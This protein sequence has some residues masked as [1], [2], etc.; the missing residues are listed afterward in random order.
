M[1]SMMFLL[2]QGN[3]LTGYPATPGITLNFDPGAQSI[4]ITTRVTL[5]GHD[6]SRYRII[7]PRF[8]QRG[9]LNGIVQAEN[10]WKP[11]NELQTTLIYGNIEGLE[12]NGL[13]GNVSSNNFSLVIDTAIKKLS[14]SSF[15]D[16]FSEVN[17][18]VAASSLE[19]VKIEKEFGSADAV[20]SIIDQLVQN[21]K[22]GGR[23]LLLAKTWPVQV[24][25]KTRELE[26]QKNWRILSMETWVNLSV[27]NTYGNASYTLYFTETDDYYL[28]DQYVIGGDSIGD[29]IQYSLFSGY[30]RLYRG[31]PAKIYKLHLSNITR[32]NYAVLPN[33]T[34][35]SMTV[36]HVAHQGVTK[37]IGLDGKYPILKKLV[38]GTLGTTNDTSYIDIGSSDGTT[39]EII[40]PSCIKFVSILEVHGYKLVIED[41]ENLTTCIFAGATG[42][43]INAGSNALDIVIRDSPTM[44]GVFDMSQVDG[45]NATVYFGYRCNGLV[46]PKSL[47]FQLY[48]R[49]GNAY[50]RVMKGMIYQCYNGYGQNRSVVLTN[51][52][53]TGLDWDTYTGEWAISHWD[54]QK[55]S[56]TK[57]E[58]EKIINH[59]YN[60]SFSRPYSFDFREQSPYYLPDAAAQAKIDAI[61]PQV[62]F[63]FDSQAEFDIIVN[64]AGEEK[65]NTP[66]KE[67][68]APGS[69]IEYV[70]GRY[71]FNNGDCHIFELDVTRDT[72]FE[73][74]YRFVVQGWVI[75]DNINWKEDLDP[76]TFL[77]PS[78]RTYKIINVFEQWLGDTMISRIE[79]PRNYA[80]PGMGAVPA[81]T[82]L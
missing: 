49:S 42:A 41:G 22:E 23:L 72:E 19:F 75:T 1:D 56:F 5:E 74:D 33:V 62:T 82:L 61:A 15:S 77:A 16:H 11:G 4:T 81:L 52:Q 2:I 10:L 48:K 40:C 80:G 36:R 7:S 68:S 53:F 31:D 29:S 26:V 27:Y 70:Y 24:Y 39:A 30:A 59:F 50:V 51:Q 12:I 21:G 45:E 44:D 69:W 25:N 76:A 67:K 79:S 13:Y 8:D 6:G 47:D 71:F 64:G 3:S 18:G 78:E 57:T 38:I 54:F 20:V 43:V 28:E 14:L 63:S 37:N 58:I 65:F 9:V 55:N 17:L 35:I 32:I 34:E 60:G 46:M 73:I 66:Y